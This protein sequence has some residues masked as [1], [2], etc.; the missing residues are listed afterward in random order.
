MHRDFG[1]CLS[2]ASHANHSLLFPLFPMFSLHTLIIQYLQAHR[3]GFEEDE[4]LRA[5]WSFL[6]NDRILYCRRF[7]I[8]M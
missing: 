6:E 5:F 7:F 1:L 8:L 3:E 4:L 2:N